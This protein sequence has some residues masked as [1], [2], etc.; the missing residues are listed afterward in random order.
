MSTSYLFFISSTSNSTLLL[1]L[2][3]LLLLLLLLIKSNNS[4]FHCSKFWNTCSHDHLYHDCD[5]HH[6][7]ISVIIYFIILDHH[8]NYCQHQ[9]SCFICRI[10]IE[11]SFLTCTYGRRTNKVT[12]RCMRWGDHLKRRSRQYRRGTESIHCDFGLPPTHPLVQV[13]YIFWLFAGS[14]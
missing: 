7:F 6:K 2:L 10:F 11:R 1:Q 4:S 13:H 14:P 3:L 12:Y 9:S 5:D 8:S